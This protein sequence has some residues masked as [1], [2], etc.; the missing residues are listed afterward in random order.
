MVNTMP[1][2]KYGTAEDLHI[3]AAQAHTAAGAKHRRGHH[4]AAEERSP[5]VQGNSKAAC[6]KSLEIAKQLRAHLRA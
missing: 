4:E 1:Q 5:T 3:F 6:E 2:S